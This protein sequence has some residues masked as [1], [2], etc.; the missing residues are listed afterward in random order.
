MDAKPSQ[1]APFHYSSK[2]HWAVCTTHDVTI[3]F[4]PISCTRCSRAAT[5]GSS[6]QTESTTSCSSSSSGPSTKCRVRQYADEPVCATESPRANPEHLQQHVQPKSSRGSPTIPCAT[7]LRTTN[8]NNT[9]RPGPSIQRAAQP[10]RPSDD[11]GRATTSIYHGSA[12]KRDSTCA[13]TSNQSSR[14]KCSDSAAAKSGILSSAAGWC[15]RCFCRQRQETRES[16]WCKSAQSRFHQDSRGPHS[17]GRIHESD[18]LAVKGI[19]RLKHSI[20]ATGIPPTRIVK[21]IHGVEG[22]GYSRIFNLRL[23]ILI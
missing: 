16:S 6:E 13:T 3:R 15:S 17:R 7:W 19:S 22:L 20:S 2:V 5:G 10:L 14:S 21:I 12:A 4:Q 18:P 11:E 1:T 23:S 9:A 8:G